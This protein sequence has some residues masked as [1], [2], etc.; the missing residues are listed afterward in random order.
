MIDKYCL[1][2]TDSQQ[3]V[4]RIIDSEAT[5]HMAH[6]FD[7]FIKLDFGRKGGYVRLADDKN[8]LEVKGIAKVHSGLYNLSMEKAYTVKGPIHAECT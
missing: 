5:N 3:N 8:C 4:N 7:F 6:Y 1:R 2:A